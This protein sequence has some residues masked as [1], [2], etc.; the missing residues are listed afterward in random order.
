MSVVG[1]YLLRKKVGKINSWLDQN[2]IKNPFVSLQPAGS[3]NSTNG[4]DLFWL[5]GGVHIGR[6]QTLL[7]V[8]PSSFIYRKVARSRLVY[9]SILNSFGQRSQYI[10]INF[11]FINSL[12][13]LECATNWDTTARDFTVSHIWQ[14]EFDFFLGLGSQA[15]K[16]KFIQLS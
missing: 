8:K 16:G 14:Q 11:P 5:G 12:I 10:N 15:S 9:Y 4:S 2:I 7:T 13:T 6:F 3:F 1:H